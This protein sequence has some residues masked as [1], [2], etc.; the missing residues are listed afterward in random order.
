[1]SQWISH[2]KKYSAANNVPYNVALSMAAPSYHSQKGGGLMQK[3]H[4]FVKKHKL[5]SKAGHLAATHLGGQHSET[6]HK[7][8]N[9]A[10]SFGYGLVK[11]RRRRG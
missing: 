8:A 9:A 11:K 6:I 2:V 5:L 1:M 7:L 3:A 10:D 4:T